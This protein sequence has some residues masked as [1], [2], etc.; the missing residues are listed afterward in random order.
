MLFKVM[1]R[2]W[3][4]EVL[5]VISDSIDSLIVS[6]NRGACSCSSISI[7]SSEDDDESFTTMLPKAVHRQSA[8]LF[9]NFSRMICEQCE[10]NAWKQG[11]NS[12]AFSPMLSRQI[13][14]DSTDNWP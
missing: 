3:S 6:L 11:S 2:H 7:S 14:H 8:H 10:Q 13:V 1:S 5:D 4:N 9:C 12:T